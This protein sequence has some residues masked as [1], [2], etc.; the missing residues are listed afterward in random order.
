MIPYMGHLGKYS[1]PNLYHR[2]LEV[3]C[4]KNQ[5]EGGDDCLNLGTSRIPLESPKC[6]VLPRPKSKQ[7]IDV[8]PLNFVDDS[9]R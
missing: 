2:G 5:W 8:E 6:V 7:H 4:T 3:L 1:H 9:S